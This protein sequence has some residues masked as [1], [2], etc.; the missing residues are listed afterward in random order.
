VLTGS[1]PKAF[2]DAVKRARA[3]GACDF[4]FSLERVW[5]CEAYRAGDGVHRAWLERRA[6]AEPLWRRWGRWFNRKHAELLKLEERL[7]SPEGAGLIIANSRMV[8]EE[9]VRHYGYPAERIRVIYNGLPRPPR[10]AAGSAEAELRARIRT[11]F[12]TQLGAGEEECLILFAGS[13]WERKG[14]RQAIEAVNEARFGRKARLIVAG[15]GNPGCMPRSGRVWYAGPVKSRQEMEAYYAGCDLF[16]LPTLYD[17]F[18]NASLEAF[19]AGLPVIT[20]QANGFSE[21]LR[22]G[23]EG[24]ALPDPLDVAA[25]ARA[26]ESWSDPARAAAIRPHNAARAAEFSIEAN[27]RETLAALGLQ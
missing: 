14:L 16:V 3:F 23:E 22:P 18:S 19:A 25:L 11:Q 5:N 20:T 26:L 4:L 9:I 12:R 13:G 27:V 17:P 2:A 10:Q 7:F 21:V 15:K 6:A 24:E 1:S 8:K